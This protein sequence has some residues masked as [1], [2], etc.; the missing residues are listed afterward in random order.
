MNINRVSYERSVQDYLD[1]LLQ[2]FE[3]PGIQYLVVDEQDIRFEYYG[4]QRNLGAQLPVTPETTFMASSS[5][6][7]LT[8]AAVLQLVEQGKVQLDRSLSAYYPNHPYGDQVTIRHLLNQTSG[9]RNP[10]PLKWLHSV[11][12]HPTFDESQ[13]LKVALKKHAK[14]AFMPGDKYAYSNISYWLLGAVIQQ[15]SGQAYCDYMRQNIFEPLGAGRE[16]LNCFI[17]DP[18]HHAQG[19]QK[20][21]SLLGLFLYFM[22]DKTLIEGTKS[23]WFGLRPVY[24]NGPA[25]G[26][27]IGTARGFAKFLQDQLRAKPI[28]FN[29]KIP[30]PSSTRLRKIIGVRHL[31]LP[32]AGTE[33]G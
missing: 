5:T 2:K 27:L 14:L 23:G 13:A 31:K 25:Y 22:M 7:P 21:Y 11:E 1:R 3:I 6:K 10:L 19:Y 18:T 8:A 15:V 16:E 28:L 32:L 24:M 20:K 30:K 26:G 4:G 29:P 33:A 12:E 17:S 9:I